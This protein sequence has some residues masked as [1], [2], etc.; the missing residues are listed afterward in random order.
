MNDRLTESET[1]APK[2]FRPTTIPFRDNC[3][4]AVFC[5]FSTESIALPENISNERRYLRRQGD[6]DN[7]FIFNSVKKGFNKRG[8]RVGCDS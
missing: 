5:Y 3:K 1:S 4:T 7:D 2:I 8:H 6:A